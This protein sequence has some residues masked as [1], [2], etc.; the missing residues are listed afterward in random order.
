MFKFNFGSS[1]DPL[2]GPIVKES[3]ELDRN[4]CQPWVEIPVEES[5]VSGDCLS[6]PKS[7]SCS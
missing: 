1:D 5:V 3:N 7:C 4:A 2:S 6:C